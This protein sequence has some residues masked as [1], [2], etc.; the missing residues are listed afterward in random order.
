MNILFDGDSITA[1]YDVL[2]NK[3]T[4]YGFPLI[5]KEKL[6]CTYQNNAVSGQ[7]STNLVN[8]LN[9]NFIPD[10]FILEIGANDAWEKVKY[11]KVTTDE[12][13]YNNLIEILNKINSLN[14]NVKVII[15][16]IATSSTN[17]LLDEIIK[18]NNIIKKV[19]V[20]HN[21]LLIDTFTYFNN[22]L[23][24]E[25]KENLFYDD[26]IHYK[27]SSHKLISLE[28]LKYIK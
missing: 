13:F 24:N 11:N 18:K 9:N 3:D 5:I 2:T 25:S 26:D 14:S 6:N 16:T 23:K 10:Y 8:R 27:E 22:L 28:I 17:E 1:C 21:L 20:E 15:Q 7:T 4:M 12:V 19:A